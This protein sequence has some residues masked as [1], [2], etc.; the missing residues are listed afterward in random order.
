MHITGGCYCGQIT[1]TAEVDPNKVRIC[2]CKDCQI[3][4]GS[5][6]RTVL[7]VAEADY[8]LLTGTPKIYV[9]T[10][11]SGR[12]R[13]QAFCPDCGTPLYATSVGGEPRVFGIRTGSIDQRADLVPTRQFWA[14]SKLGWVPDMPHMSSVDQQ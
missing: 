8:K 9:K 12:P 7:P 10:A 11:E 5:A 13:E 2:Q 1:F 3:L 6:F 4:S 14:Q